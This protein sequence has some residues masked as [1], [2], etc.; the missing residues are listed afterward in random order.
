[1][2]IFFLYT[3]QKGSSLL[4]SKECISSTET[5]NISLTVSNL[6]NRRKSHFNIYSTIVI[7]P[8]GWLT[9]LLLNLAT[10]KLEKLKKGNFKLKI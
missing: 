1:M 6:K 2:K 9:I 10:L 5:L 4:S 3:N 7:S 8:E